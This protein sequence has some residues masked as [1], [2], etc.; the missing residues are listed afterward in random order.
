MQSRATVSWMRTARVAVLLSIA[1]VMQALAEPTLVKTGLTAQWELISDRDGI[2]VY[3]RHTENSQLKTFRGVTRITL[4][5]ENALVALLED[6]D[7]VP[8]W[9]HFVDGAEELGRDSPLKRYMRFTTEVP[10][11]LT[12]REAVVQT[13]ISQRITPGEEQITIHISNRP[14]RIPTNPDYVRFPEMGGMFKL[15]RL[16]DRQVEITYQLVMDP[17][18]YVPVWLANIMLRDAPYFTLLKL[19]RFIRNPEYQNQYFDYLEVFG[20]GRPDDV[21]APRSYLY[22]NPPAEPLE[23]MTLEMMNPPR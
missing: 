15:Q 17:G 1:L 16:G 23:H 21:A 22:G 9:M 11:P 13:D 20:P 2:Q 4:E 7:S 3:T 14:E 19:R 10:W 5:D 8:K 12:D 6:H 18:G